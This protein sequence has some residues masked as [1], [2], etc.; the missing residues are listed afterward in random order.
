MNVLFLISHDISLRFGCYGDKTAVTPNIDSLAS[1]GMVFENHFCQYALCAPSRAN[2]FTGCRPDT[3][4]RFNIGPNEWFADFRREHSWV[5]TLPEVLKSAGWHTQSLHKLYHECEKDPPSWSVEQW[6]SPWEASQPWMPDDFECLDRATRYRNPSNWQ[7]MH[8]QFSALVAEEPEAAT[9]FKRW[10]GPPV[11]AAD[12]PDEEYPAGKVAAKACETLKG[13]A[14]GEQPFFLGVG[15]S[16][17]HLPWLSPR[18]YWELFPE[19][20]ITLPENGGYIDGLPDRYRLFGNEAYQY[21]EQNYH[22]PGATLSWKPD[23]STA[24]EMTR[25]YYAAVSYLDAQVGRILDCLNKTSVADDTIVVFTT[26]HGFALGEHGH[27]G[28]NCLHEPDLRVPLIIRAPSKDLGDT[29]GSSD[30]ATSHT[31]SCTA[32]RT[33]ALTEHV[34]IFPTVCDLVGVPAPDF[35]E[36]SSLAPLM[37]DPGRRWKKAIFNQSRKGDGMGYSVRSDRYRY[38]RWIAGNGEVKQEELYDYQIDPGESLSIHAEP[39]AAASLAE[40]R[41]IFEGGWQAVRNEL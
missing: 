10:R 13:L 5:R 1:G 40:M 14:G 7:V 32:G 19:S 33:T 20:K 8:E 9:Q 28:K 26:D 12:V 2:L 35:L 38:T 11:E 41:E 34:D 30:R 37:R 25:G 3:V 6:Y 17:T 21:F 39:S 18:R 16:V 27:W 24:F 4:K 23:K 36:G 29:P 15:F 22:Q 31:A